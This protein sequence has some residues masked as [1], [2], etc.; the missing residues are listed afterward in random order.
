[1]VYSGEYLDGVRHFLF[2]FY[3][4]KLVVA[5]K[6]LNDIDVKSSVGVVCKSKSFGDFKIVSYSDSKN[7]LIEFINTGF[8]T[9]TRSD[10]VRDGRVRDRPPIVTGKQIG[11]AHV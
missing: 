3:R 8:L 5:S 2:C 4:R 1:M 7:V 11:R 6:Y 10:C 9:S